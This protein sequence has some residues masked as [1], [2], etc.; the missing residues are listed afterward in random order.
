MYK[1]I[2]TLIFLSIALGIGTPALAQVVTGTIVGSVTDST[3][4]AVAGAKVTVKNVERNIVQAEVTTDTSGQYVAPYLPV[5]HYEVSAEMAKFKKAIASNITLNVD[6]KLTINLTLEVGAATES[7]FVRADA[8]QVDLQ[9]ATA[10]GLVSDIEVKELPLNARNYEQL[11]TLMPGVSYSSGSDT[12]YIGNSLPSGTTNV[13]PF[14]FNGLR[15]SANN[16]TIDGADNV[17]RG[18]NQTVLNYPS[19]D[20][21]QEFKVLR[22]QYNAEFGR[23]S[24]GQIIVITKSGGNSFHGG[25]YEFFRNDV[26]QAN[27]FFNNANGIARPPLRWNDFGYTI[28]GPAYIPKVYNG[29]NKTFFFYSQEVR[30]VITYGTVNALVPASAM[31]SGTFAH[32][33]CTAFS[34]TGTC[35]AT[36]T[37][38]ASISP[39][40]AQYIQDIWSKIPGPNSGT[41][42]LFVPLRNVFDANQQLVRIDHVFGPRFSIFGRYLHDGIPTVEPGG[43]FTGAALPGVSTTSTNSPGKN[44]VLHTLFTFSPRL[45]NEAGFQYSYGAIISRPVGL[46]ASTNSP[47][48]RPTLPFPVTL[49]R[50]P[51]VTVSGISS[52]TGF[53]PYNDYNRDYNAFS[54]Q[55]WIRGSHTFKFGLS[56]HHYQKTENA[57]GNNV[58][59][60]SVTTA[61]QPTTTG[62]TTAERGWANFLLGRV[63]TFT[64]SSLDITPDIRTSQV[65]LYAQD[66]Y[67]VRR[68]LTLTL[69]V[70]YSAFREPTDDR[71][72]LTN[73]VPSLYD[74]AK[75]PAIDSSGN[76]C[77]VAPCAGGAVPNPN[78]NPLNGIAVNGSSSPFGAKVSNEDNRN[79]APRIGFAWDPF[80]TGKTSVRGGYGIFYDATLFGVVEQ[81]IFQNPPFVQSTT[82]VNT[83]LDNPAAGTPRI[84]AL[85]GALRATPSPYHSPYVQEWDLDIQRE[86]GSGFLVD[87]GYYGSKS[88]HLIGIADINQPPVGAYVNA[89]LSTVV[90]GTNIT[91]GSGG[92]QN[93]NLLNLIRPY[94]GYG[95]INAIQSRYNAN[96][97]GLQTSLQKR[98]QRN[99]LV[100]VYYTYSK[101]LTDNQTD[102]STPPQNVYNINAEYGPLQQDRTHILTADIVYALPWLADQQGLKGRFLGGWQTSGILSV[103]SGLPLTVGTFNPF[104]PAGQGVQLSSSAASIRPDQISNPNSGAPHTVSQWFNTAAFADV[105]GTQVRPGS[106]PRG[107]VRGPGYQIWNFALQKYIKVHESANFQFRAEAF[108]VFN[109]T[110]F[111]GV[112]TTLG[113]ATY[114][115]ITSTRDPRVLQLGLKFNF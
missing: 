101:A 5:G 19:V 30:R 99:S 23:G 85:P 58:G 51:A 92:V 96:Y 64:Q 87:V 106:E 67:R 44:L 105:P 93:E 103:A 42:T 74:A 57:A 76:I 55:T 34:S 110:N 26:L 98:F 29:R 66:D 1:R 100:G 63:A 72:F 79:F 90:G 114:G 68:N 88:T 78:Y 11:V 14:S 86:L 37:Q 73:F 36:G 62:A 95:P 39:V 17:D 45:I 75:A 50:V 61:G 27:S 28:G 70:R 49:G 13:V 69:G 2:S 111:F 22:G 31:K 80:N 8:L 115:K 84:S 113:A 94:K 47:D 107:T 77:T 32:S 16:W 4:A 9:S 53:G 18:S 108:N 43:L 104:D 71:R 52:I 54:N 6:D 20:S 38:I 83:S 21:I 3:G 109:H 102:R 65:E 12:L 112:G 33:V 82:I 7:I 10:S 81:N 59:T 56:Y 25:A 91:V 46:D 89:G 60:F 41:S 40:A 35:S 97:N 15:N 48:I 24:A